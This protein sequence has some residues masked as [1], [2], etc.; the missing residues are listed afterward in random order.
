MEYKI[1]KGVL[2][3]Q[4][5]ENIRNFFFNP[6]TPWYYQS[7][8]LIKSQNDDRGFFSHVLFHENK[9]YSEGYSLFEPLINKLNIL[10]LINLRAN[11]NIKSDNRYMSEFHSDYVYKDGLTAIYYLNKCNGYTEFD[12][13]EKTK[14]YSEPNKIVVFDSSMKHRMVSQTDENRRLVVN[15]NYFPK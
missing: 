13:K 7:K 5:F 3:K 10:S 11:L 6:K 9:I 8:M 1:F 14:V 2:E 4:E 15:I 12:N